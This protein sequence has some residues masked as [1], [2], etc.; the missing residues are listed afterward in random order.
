MVVDSV[1]CGHGTTHIQI[2]ITES[3]DSNLSLL[4]EVPVAYRL[5]QLMTYQDNVFE[6]L[7]MNHS[8]LET[9]C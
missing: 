1:I 9:C 2:T 5:S 6:D 4:V 3:I 7:P 8:R